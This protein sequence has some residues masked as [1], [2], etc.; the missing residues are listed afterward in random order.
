MSDPLFLAT[1]SPA[2]GPLPLAPP[3]L[4]L[5]FGRQRSQPGVNRIIPLFFLIGQIAPFSL[6]LTKNGLGLIHQ[7]GPFLK[8]F[9]ITL[10]HNLSSNLSKQ[11]YKIAQRS[12]IPGLDGAGER[13]KN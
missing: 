5:D 11:F 12:L 9:L 1:A 10:V 7:V 4:A 3:L 6:R 8:E 2:R 13:M